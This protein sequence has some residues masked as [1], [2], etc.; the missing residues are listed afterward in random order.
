[1]P[2]Q[3]AHLCFVG[4]QFLPRCS[5]CGHSRRTTILSLPIAFFTIAWHKMCAVHNTCSRLAR[6]RRRSQAGDMGLAGTRGL[7]FTIGLPRLRPVCTPS[8]HCFLLLAVTSFVT[9][10]VNVYGMCYVLVRMAENKQVGSSMSVSVWLAFSLSS[11]GLLL[12]APF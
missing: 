2:C 5:P 1:V 4:S 6:L 3:H 9:Q 12:F 7:V 10:V 8:W 11:V